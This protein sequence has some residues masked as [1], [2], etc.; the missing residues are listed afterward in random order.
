MSG[1]RG[2]TGASDPRTGVR[3]WIYR[4][5]GLRGCGSTPDPSDGS[6]LV[7]LEIC[8]ARWGLTPI[9]DPIFGHDH[10]SFWRSRTAV[11]RAAMSF[12]LELEN[13]LGCIETNDRVLVAANLPEHVDMRSSIIASEL[14]NAVSL[15]LAP[16]RF[17]ASRLR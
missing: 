3:R 12:G 15:A 17:H 9:K 8:W 14:V 7:R 2:A 11:R 13:G 16:L 10:P 5:Y 6:V 1:S 4:R